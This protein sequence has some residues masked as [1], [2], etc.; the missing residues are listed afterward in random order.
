MAEAAEIARLQAEI[1]ALK[2]QGISVPTPP[3]PAY[4]R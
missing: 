4:H 2:A 1:A 3:P